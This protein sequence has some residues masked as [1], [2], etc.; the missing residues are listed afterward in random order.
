M[1][2]LKLIS[3]NVNGL[4]AVNNKGFLDFIDQYQPDIL[5]LQEIKCLPEQL[6]P[7]LLNI[8]N[9]KVIFNSAQKKG[10][11]GTAIYS[12]IP[13]ISHDFGI[14][15]YDHDN[16]GRVITAIFDKFILVN[17]YTPNS[18]RMLERLGERQIW[19]KDFTKFLNNLKQKHQKPV[20]CCGD[21]NVA[22]HEIDLARPQQNTKNAGFT[23][24][25]RKG[26]QHHLNNN[27]IDTFRHLHP[28]Q[29]DAYTWWSYQ[30]DS[31]NRN[32]GWRIDYFLLDKENTSILTQAEIH[33]DVHGSDHCPVSINIQI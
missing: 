13:F 12:K 14:E 33:P 15:H 5:C 1:Q 21:L 28:N 27:F 7:E 23:I 22:H 4:R 20:L 17:V 26:F 6:P 10:Y 32:V 30:G 3:W 8:P 24:E 25:E 9:Y 29:T 19:D 31:R 18:K 11:S 16:E 2:N